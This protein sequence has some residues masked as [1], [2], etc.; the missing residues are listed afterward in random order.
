[1]CLEG[2][3]GAQF[4]ITLAFAQLEAG[5]ECD[6]VAVPDRALK[7]G[8]SMARNGS[9]ERPLRVRPMLTQ[10]FLAR[11]WN[12]FLGCLLLSAAGWGVLALRSSAD[13]FPPFQVVMFT[14]TT[15]VLLYGSLAVVCLSIWAVQVLWRPAA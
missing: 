7:R 9:T 2:A 10:R 8:R 5:T 12:I 14:P 15:G 3:D 11:E 1:M 4:A 6:G 13:Y